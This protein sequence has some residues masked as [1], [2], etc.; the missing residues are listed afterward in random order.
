MSSIAD[1]RQDYKMGA[2]AETEVHKNPFIQFNQWWAQALASNIA[3]VN[4]MALATVNA[5]AIPSVRIVLLKGV[6]D[7]GFQFFTNYESQKATDIQQNPNVALVLFWKE[8][9][10]QVRIE[11]T[12][13]KLASIESDTYYHSRPI[14]SQIGAWASPQSS[15]IADRTILEKNVAKAK[16]QFENSPITRPPFWGGYLV[17]PNKIEFWQGRSNR[18]HDRLLYAKVQEQWV[19]KRLAP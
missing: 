5:N 2:L 8:L 14:D 16:V 19:I 4:A 18:L 12:V 6:T 7:E 13:Q 11:G 3:E 1:I 17:I 9:E 10:R 15:Q